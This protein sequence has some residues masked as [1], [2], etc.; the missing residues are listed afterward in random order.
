MKSVLIKS[1]RPRA[2]DCSRS[3]AKRRSH[4]IFA[5]P[6]RI[7]RVAYCHPV[8]GRWAAVAS[9][10]PAAIERARPDPDS[11]PNKVT[12][13]EVVNAQGESFHVVVEWQNLESI[14]GSHE[15]VA[16]VRE[17]GR[18]G[19]AKKA[20]IQRFESGN[21][22]QLVGVERRGDSAVLRF[23]SQGGAV[24]PGREVIEVRCTVTAAGLRRLPDGEVESLELQGLPSCLRP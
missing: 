23:R 10:R 12:F 6:H 3:A 11:A 14:P 9:D 15:I 17:Y 22:N 19:L 2:A 5:L 21:R 24:V 1:P 7:R 16:H 4:E 18:D 20:T 8:C 13:P